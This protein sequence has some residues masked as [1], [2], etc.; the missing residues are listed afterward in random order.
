MCVKGETRAVRPMPRVTKSTKTDAKDWCRVDSSYVSVGALG[1]SSACRV[2]EVKPPA[3][4]HQ[5]VVV[6][7]NL[8]NRPLS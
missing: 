1:W 7:H 2:S 4:H 5:H 3:G 8:S 6:T